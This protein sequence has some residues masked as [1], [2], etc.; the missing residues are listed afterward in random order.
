MAEIYDVDYELQMENLL[1]PQN[2]AQPNL[3]FANSIIYPLQ[4]AH[5]RLFDDYRKG[6]QYLQY[7]GATSYFIYD[8]VRF[9]K[10][11]YEL[12]VST[13][14]GVAPEGDSLSATNWKKIQD[15]YIGSQERAS[16]S[17]QT[18][19]LC[20]AMNKWFNITSPPFAWLDINSAAGAGYF[21]MIP[22]AVYTAL[23]P[24][25]QDRQNAVK[26]FID[27]YKIGGITYAVIAF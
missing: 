8:R 18:A 9:N 19:I 15:I 16:W 25:T 2:R 27:R 24:T 17:P 7:V 1:S 26:Q 4:D 11:I 5:N 12:K 6:A 22:T 21:V 10:A 23:G 3:D 14:T 20:Y 13:S